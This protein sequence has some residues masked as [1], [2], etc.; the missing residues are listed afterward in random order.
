MSSEPSANY[1]HHFT[2]LGR[3]KNTPI[4]VGHNSKRNGYHG[5]KVEALLEGKWTA[6]ADFPI[7]GG[8]NQYS[9][10]NFNDVLYLF[11]KLI[12]VNN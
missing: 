10:V 6:L 5:N 1:N 2:S 7:A 11:G 9:M 4:A 3:L 12:S 8:I